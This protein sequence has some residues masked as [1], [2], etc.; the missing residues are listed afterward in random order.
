[1][2]LTQLSPRTSLYHDM[3]DSSE[4]LFNQ[5][6]AG[7]LVDAQTSQTTSLFTIPDMGTVSQ[8]VILILRHQTTSKLRC[9]TS[10]SRVRG[11]SHQGL[12]LGSLDYHDCMHR[13][14]PTIVTT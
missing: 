3:T 5:I 11:R 13:P 7:A 12:I 1:V 14:T 8:A 2:G 9:N 6:K 10:M 4:A